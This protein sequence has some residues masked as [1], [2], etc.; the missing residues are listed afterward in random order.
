MTDTSHF[1]WVGLM[2]IQ[3]RLRRL[4]QILIYDKAMHF[5]YFICNKVI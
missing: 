2:S 1:H 4:W 5:Q 3:G